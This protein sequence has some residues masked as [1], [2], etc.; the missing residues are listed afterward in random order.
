[1]TVIPI[2]PKPHGPPL[3]L[4]T[5]VPQCLVLQM[6]IKLR[7]LSLFCTLLYFTLLTRRLSVL[8]FCEHARLPLGRSMSIF[9]IWIALLLVLMSWSAHVT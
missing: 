7:G 1:M 4:P 2:L 5:F 3:N 6:I 8:F 9:H